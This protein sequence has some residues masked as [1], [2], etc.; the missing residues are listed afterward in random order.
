MARK[1]RRGLSDLLIILLAIG[2]VLPLFGNYFWLFELP[3]H[4]KPHMAILA[5]LLAIYS[6]FKKHIR[7]TMLAMLL[8]LV[9]SYIFIPYFSQN[10][11]PD[12]TLAVRVMTTNLNWANSRVTSVRKV[13][14]NLNPHVIGLLETNERWEQELQEVGERYNSYYHHG[15]DDGKFGVAIMSRYP[16]VDLKVINLS[17]E[18]Y[19]SLLASIDV[20]GDEVRALVV[21]P[22]PPMSAELTRIRNEQFDAIAEMGRADPR[23]IVMGDFNST[24]WVPGFRRLSRGN[25]LTLTS[26]G[27]P[28]A[29]TWPTELGMMGIPIDHILISGGMRVVRHESARNIGSDH[30]PVFADIVFGR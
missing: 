4:F 26:R 24:P 12:P 25:G 1:R 10:K 15:P 27:F 5:L 21:H 20:N 29:T 23:L 6:I 7:F 9:N 18:A 3:G 14:E 8:V 17:D 13:I 2:T 11:V 30:R 22:P 16:I 19:P 28:Y